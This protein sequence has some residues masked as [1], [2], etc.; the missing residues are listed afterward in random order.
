VDDG[1]IAV[2]VRG[3][4]AGT[5]LEVVG[6]DDDSA[7]VSA[8]AGSDYTYAGRRAQL[9]AAAAPLGVELPSA[10]QLATLEVDGVEYVR[11]SGAFVDV[12]GPAVERTDARILFVA[13]ER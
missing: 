6:G 4:A 5:S 13:P 12:A 3:V 9:H 8:H 10:A 11:R 7:R 2:I 1:R